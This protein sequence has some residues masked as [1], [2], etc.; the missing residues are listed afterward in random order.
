MKLIAIAALAD[1]NGIGQNG[2]LLFNCKEDMRHFVQTTKGHAV[3]MGRK[4]FEGIGK[5][6]KDRL[7][8]I[9]SENG[10]LSVYGAVVC[11][12]IATALD[13]AQSNGFK[14]L[15]ICGGGNV[16]KK[17]F[18]LWDEIIIS[19]FPISMR[20]DTYFPIITSSDWKHKKD[21]EQVT[22]SNGELMFSIHHLTRIHA[23]QD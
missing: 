11:H 10:E 16:Y 8:I 20:A 1:N 18:D 6:L 12:S 2:R 7:N 23:D 4:T 3:L 13:Y 17:T 22:G 14:K 15:F 5:P 9:L 21:A 19:K